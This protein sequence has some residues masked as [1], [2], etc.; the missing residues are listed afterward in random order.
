MGFWHANAQKDVGN[1]KFKT[2]VVTVENRL[3]GNSFLGAL[4]TSS[5]EL[6]TK[7]DISSNTAPSIELNIEEIKYLK[8]KRRGS[9][10]TGFFVGGG[11]GA[12]IGFAKGTTEGCSPL[13]GFCSP[14]P[15]E[16]NALT[17]GILGA[18]AGGII[19]S[20]IDGSIKV[21]LNGNQNIYE[22]KKADM[23]KYQY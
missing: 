4:K 18:L 14:T 16:E 21:T 6:Y 17:F 5:I 13:T 19:A 11:I 8:F 1:K 22:Q 20:I 23:Y 3:I 2:Q 7:S 15:P 9:F 10:L 12:G